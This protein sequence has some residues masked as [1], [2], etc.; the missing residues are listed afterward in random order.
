[1]NY[2]TITVAVK[3]YIRAFLENNFGSPVDIRK[4][5]ELNNM[6]EFLL[7]EGATRLDKTLQIKYTDTV[8][9]RISRDTFHRYGFTLTKTATQRLNCYLEGRIKFFAR[10]YIANNRS[11]GIPLARCIRDFQEK[12]NFPEDVW[13]AEAI[14]KDFTRNG[15]TV[16]SKFIT[17]FKNEL[18]KIFLEFMSESGTLSK[19][20]PKSGQE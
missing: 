20:F 6:V 15:K 12:F 13:S 3:P 11:I 19:S 8:C 10:V 9:F 18:N 2:Y 4:D 7:K 5:P 16:Q 1:M 14:R 17:N